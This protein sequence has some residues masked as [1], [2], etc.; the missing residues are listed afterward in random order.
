MNLMGYERRALRIPPDGEQ[1]AGCAERAVPKQNST[2][3]SRR[4]TSAGRLFLIL[5][6]AVASYLV[7]GHRPGS[8][9]RAGDKTEAAVPAAPKERAYH[10]PLPQS[11]IDMREMILAAVHAGDV[12]ELKDAIA[13][14]EIQPDFGAGNDDP[15]AYWKRISADGEG[16][17]VLAVLADLLALPPARLAIGRDPENMMVYVWPYLAELPP[18]GLRP[19]EEVDLYR[20]MPATAAKAAKDAKKWLWW[21]LAIGADGTW[22]TFRKYE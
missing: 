21:R 8:P 9:A 13:W 12:T 10:G 14:N 16:R 15:I 1:R 4:W 19:A 11:V 5:L 22:H 2:I 20:I 17:E 7:H 6:V 3:R 18:D